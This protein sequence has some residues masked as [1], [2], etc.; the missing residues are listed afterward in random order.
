MRAVDV[1]NAIT[2]IGVS[3]GEIAARL[4]VP[5]K[6]L[7]AW[8]AGT[9]TP[10][11]R[12]AKQLKWEAD[13]AQR[14]RAATEAGYARCPWVEEWGVDTDV[15]LSLDEM[16]RRTADLDAHEKD[17]TACKSRRAFLEA[18]FPDASRFPIGFLPRVLGAL[19]SAAA[20][21]PRP[22]RPP[23]IGA[24]ALAGIVI[25]PSAPF[26]LF[27]LL[28]DVQH[29]AATL[30][31]WISAVGLASAFGASGGVMF[32]IVRPITRHLGGVGDY[33]TG[34]ASAFGYL[35][36]L[37]WAMPK[38]DPEMEDSLPLDHPFPWVVVVLLSVVFGLA[39]TYGWKRESKR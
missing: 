26:V 14:D 18:R 12:A 19:G 31:Q 11:G 36:A 9:K 27:F 32:A 37:F 23:V 33:L 24:A 25:V 1:S 5:L 2:K 28:R 21:V 16:E 22:L 34:I 7:D 13:E 3:R 4:G 38:V 6:T 30:V 29:A 20:K 35:A 17:C 8:V 10:R 39:G 15:S